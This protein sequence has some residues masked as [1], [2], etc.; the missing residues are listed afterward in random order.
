MDA[1]EHLTTIAELA[2]A[3]AGF[4]GIFVVLRHDSGSARRAIEEARLL[5]AKRERQDDWDEESA[6]RMEEAIRRILESSN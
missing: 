3:F 6:R 5:Y 4:A 1:F 2:V